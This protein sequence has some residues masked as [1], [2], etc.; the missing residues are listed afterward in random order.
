[1]QRSGINIIPSISWAVMDDFE[2]CL[3][4]IPQHSSVAIST[5]GCKSEEYSKKMFLEGTAMLQQ[6]LK[7]YKLIVCG[8]GFSELEEYQNIIYYPSYS[9]R[10]HKKLKEEGRQY[11]FSFVKEL[12]LQY[13]FVA[14]V[15]KIG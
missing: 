9:Q 13:A 12:P 3:D 11:E 8:S 10:L 15:A 2:W 7:P 6:K 1:M 14:P 4:G 5:N